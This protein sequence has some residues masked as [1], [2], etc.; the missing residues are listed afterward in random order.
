LKFEGW[1]KGAPVGAICNRDGDDMR[2]IQRRIGAKIGRGVVGD[3]VKR[4][5]HDPKLDTASS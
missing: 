1:P 5:R 2:E 3:I 4:I